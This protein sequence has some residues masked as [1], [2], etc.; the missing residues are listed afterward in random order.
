MYRR[1]DNSRTIVRKGVD[2]DNRWVVPYNPT[3]LR[4]Y[5]AHLNVEKTKQLI[6]E[7]NLN[8]LYFSI[9]KKGSRQNITSH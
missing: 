2:L 6:R 3:L 9:T 4:L 1:R 7:K 5:K 8:R